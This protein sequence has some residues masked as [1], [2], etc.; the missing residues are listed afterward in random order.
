M[1]DRL[2]YR[3]R[4][5]VDDRPGSLGRITSRLGALRGDVID[6]EIIERCPDYAVDDFVVEFP[7]SVPVA[8]I[9]REVDSE[10]GVEIEAIDRLAAGPPMPRLEALGAAAMLL[11]SQTLEELVGDL[12]DHIVRSL[13]LSWAVVVDHDLTIWAW[14]GRT[15]D[16]D[17]DH[18][19]PGPGRERVPM[20]EA[21][22]VLIVGRKI[23]LRARELD[24]TVALARIADIWARRLDGRR[25][26]DLRHS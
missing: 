26:A 8:L 3:I 2:T 11:E 25:C 23:P 19:A 14:S 13:R 18:L 16:L 12:C 9:H 21:D 17:D 10:D 15:L 1:P 22:L 6:L 5:R 20:P 7:A 4:V 24:R